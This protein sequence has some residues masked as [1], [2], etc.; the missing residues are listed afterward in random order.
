MSIIPINKEDL[1]KFGYDLAKR[2]QMAYEIT[3]CDSTKLAIEVEIYRPHLG[4]VQATVGG[5][6]SVYLM[7]KLL[8]AELRGV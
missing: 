6:L 1:L 7:I 5:M 3:V 2:Q 4:S 8:G